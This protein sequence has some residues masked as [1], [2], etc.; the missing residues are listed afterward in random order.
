MNKHRKLTYKTYRIEH[1]PYR[2]SY[3]DTECEDGWHWHVSDPVFDWELCTAD[4]LRECK[5]FVNE[6]IAFR[7]AD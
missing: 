6:R 5:D 2:L 4:T 1:V 3:S 7:Y